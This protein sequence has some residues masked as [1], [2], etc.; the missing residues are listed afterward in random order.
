MCDFRVSPN[1]CRCHLVG[2]Y[3]NR[4]EEIEAMIDVYEDRVNGWFLHHAK[5][6][7]NKGGQHVGFSVL[8]IVFS[9]FEQY[10]QYELGRD[11]DGRSKRYF[12]Y[13]FLSVFPEL[14]GLTHDERRTLIDIAYESARCGFFHSGMTRWDFFIRDNDCN[15]DP[16]VFEDEKVYIDR[17]K[18]LE[19]VENHFVDYVSKLRDKSEVSL[20]TNFETFWKLVNKGKIY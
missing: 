6:L 7:Q 13:G 2:S 9:Y 10:T 1:C 12:K 18:F 15:N 20:R 3:K 17:F 5:F 14:N 19:R 4:D 16:I 11:S 8:M